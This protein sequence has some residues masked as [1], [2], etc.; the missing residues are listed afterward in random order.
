M[1]VFSDGGLYDLFDAF[2]GHSA[3][4][5][6]TLDV[7]QTSVDAA[8]Q[9]LE[10]REIAKTFVDTKILRIVECS[11]RSQSTSLLEVLLEMEFLVLHMEAGM[12]AFL[13]YTSSKPPGRLLGNPSIKDQLHSIRAPKIE[14]VTNDL[15]KELPSTKRPPVWRVG[16]Y[17]LR[18]SRSIHSTSRVAWSR[19]RSLMFG[20]IPHNTPALI[21]W[22]S[23]EHDQGFEGNSECRNTY[24]ARHTHSS[25]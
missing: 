23:R 1:A 14:V 19:K 2:V 5:A 7:K 12:N 8:I 17:P 24:P 21:P 13:D 9:L 15:L 18:C 4:I 6:D 11:F 16:I 3:V 22:Q 25:V 20:I 10:V